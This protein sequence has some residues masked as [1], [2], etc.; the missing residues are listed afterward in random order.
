MNP[1]APAGQGPRTA[2][3]RRAS[4]L[5]YSRRLM[6]ATPSLSWR[7]AL[8][9]TLPPLLWAAN[10]VIGRLMGPLV[11]P[12]TLNFMRW[13]L[14]SLVLLPMAPALLRPG[15]PLVTHWRRFALLGLL[16]IGLYN[17]LQYQAL[18]TS[19]ALN[20]TL[21]GSSMPAFMLTIG[22][23]IYGQK[24]S[25]RQLL[26]AVLSIAGVLVVLTQGHPE[27]V[28]ELRFVPG[29]LFMLVATG[30]WAWYSWLLADTRSD[31]PGLRA[32][33]AAYLLAQVLPG[34][35]WAGLFAV[36]EY[37]LGDPV[38]IQWGWPLAAA[39]FFIA[40]GPAVLAYRIWGLGVQRLGPT[41]SGFF[42]NLTP[43]FAA[44]M[45]G[46]FLG[47]APAWHHGLAF[48]LI[49]SGIVVS[50]RRG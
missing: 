18:H 29:D 37:G 24:V 34:A 12:M 21:V 11:P 40:V 23:L 25:A 44:V 1:L 48:L 45:S 43:L 2:P 10:A 46:L 9:M 16:S 38:P 31:P 13:V 33:W 27:R 41:L 22:A 6:F 28:A 4:P 14:A 30:V 26:G 20:V 39:L 49:V 47:E 19:T 36:G 50:S 15:S 35:L 3:S 7:T 5:G 17:A 32:D 42:G 8:L